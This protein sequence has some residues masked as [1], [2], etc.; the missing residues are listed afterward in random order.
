[1]IEQELEQVE[2]MNPDFL[3]LIESDQ[4]AKLI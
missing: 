2:T 4:M 3:K 1:M